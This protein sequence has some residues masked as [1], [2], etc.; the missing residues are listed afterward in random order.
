MKP[1]TVLVVA[2]HPDDEALGCGGTIARHVAAGDRVHVQFMSDGVASRADENEANS[3]DKLRRREE[4]LAAAQVLGLALPRFADF[5]D[6]R[7]DTVPLLELVKCVEET[8]EDL[9]PNV[10][11][12]HHGG[13]LNVD[14]R[15]VHD[16]VLTACRPLPGRK[17]RAIYAFEVLSSTEWASP[18]ASRGFQPNRFVEITAEMETKLTALACY[19][20]E[21]RPPPHARSL[22]AV[23][24]MATLRGASAGVPKAEA[25]A[26]LRE[27]LEQ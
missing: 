23:K 8:V 5:P 21:M 27:V 13:D 10:V 15:L 2:A 1:A 19:G 7:L 22:E 25:F 4:A 9:A 26:V 6:N 14:H 11:Y 17:V 18:A 20:S 16:A 24:A 12:T 3:A